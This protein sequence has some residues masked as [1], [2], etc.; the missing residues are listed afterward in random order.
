MVAPAE[1][2]SEVD[3]ILPG[4]I[5]DRRWLHEHPEL[6]FHE[7]ETS[8][9]VAERLASLGVEDIRTGVGGTGVTGLIKGTR[10][11]GKVLMVRADMDALA[12]DEENDVPY[13]SQN[14]GVMHACGHDAHTAMLLGVTRIL[15]GKRD[16][17]AG[18]VKVLFQPAEEA[19]PGGA[20]PMIRDGALEDPKVD[21]SFGM[22]VMS[23]TPSGLIGVS[24]NLGTSN[25]DRFTIHVQGKG[26]HGSSPHKSVDPVVLGSHIVVALQNLVS[27]ETDPMEPAVLSITA[28]LSGEA[29]NV[30]PDTAELRGTVRSFNPD[31]QDHIERRM[32]EVAEGVAKA[33]G[34]SATVDYRRGYPALPNDATMAAIVRDAAIEVV[35]EDNVFEPPVGM[36]GEDYAYFARAVPSCFF[37]VGV[38][39]EERG[40]VWAHHHPRFDIEEEGL[41]AGLA[42]MTNAILHYLNG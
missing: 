33:L 5:A 6:G 2:R 42:T 13:K 30:I 31:V 19:H 18:T 27:R 37:W 11:D 34:G 20:L 38:R 21:A 23:D 7:V 3:E 25:S 41:S 8:K 40:I 36:G 12:I 32:S 39:N 17:F 28:L 15:M 9:F 35:G 24:A 4:V 16:E 22:H 29:F 1:I 10:G 26:G 14:P